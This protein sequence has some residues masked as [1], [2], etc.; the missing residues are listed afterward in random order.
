MPRYLYFAGAL[1]LGMMYLYSGFLVARTRTEQT[2]RKVLLASIV[3]LP[4]LYAIMLVDRT[5]DVIWLRSS[6][7]LLP[8]HFPRSVYP[9]TRP[10]QLWRS[11]GFHSH[12]PDSEPF[13][14]P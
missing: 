6:A 4:A 8:S 1:L 7:A 12:R 3:Y 5:R 14:K 11:P 13:R 9:W 2:A 10:A